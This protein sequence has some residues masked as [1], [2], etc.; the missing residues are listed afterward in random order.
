V[1]HLPCFSSQVMRILVFQK[2]S[3]ILLTS[4]A[5]VL[6]LNLKLITLARAQKADGTCHVALGENTWL[7]GSNESS[8]HWD[9]LIEKPPVTIDKKPILKNGKIMTQQLLLARVSMSGWLGANPTLP[10]QPRHPPSSF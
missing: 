5:Y 8:L 10:F 6:G 9:F 7:G 4:N 3:L 1:E 2:S